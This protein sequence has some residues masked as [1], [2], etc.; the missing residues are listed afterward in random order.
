MLIHKNKSFDLITKEIDGFLWIEEWLPQTKFKTKMNYEISSFGRVK[1]LGYFTSKQKIWKPDEII[2]GSPGKKKP[3]I[4]FNLRR[5][6][7]GNLSISA[8]RLVGFH[9][10]QKPEGKDCIN[11]KK[12]NKWDNHY[13]EIEWCTDAENNEH[14]IANG[15]NACN[16][17]L[18]KNDRNY[19][20]ENLS[21][22]T[23][24][25]WCEKY[26]ITDGYFI[27]LLA[28]NGKSVKDYGMNKKTGGG[29]KTRYGEDCHKKAYHIHTKETLSTKQIAELL[30]VSKH[31]ICRQLNGE[32]YCHIPYRYVG[33]EHLVRLPPPPKPPKEKP[34]KKERPPRKAY[35]PH[36][37]VYRKMIACDINGNEVHIFDS[38]GKAAAFVNSK[39]ETF[40]KA[41]SKSPNNY[42]K[43]YIWKYA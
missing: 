31:N 37:A 3:Y 42:T 17:K 11:H 9:F 6:E 30:G 36:P 26:E 27:A 23:R 2:L 39:P 4:K 18:S 43:G 33:E 16:S 10:L 32:R 7:G 8:H 40:R 22:F 35:V 29:A 19:I 34:P 15:L 14:A 21:L 5:H 12:G 13:T 1:R 38:S 25:E 24:E 20:L 28:R 41:I